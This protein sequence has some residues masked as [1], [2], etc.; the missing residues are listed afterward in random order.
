MRDPFKHVIQSYKHM[1]RAEADSD[2]ALAWQC[3]CE[4]VTY[5]LDNNADNTPSIG[6]RVLWR[7]LKKI[8]SG[9]GAVQQIEGGNHKHLVF[10]GIARSSAHRVEYTETETRIRPGWYIA[11]E[12]LPGHLQGKVS[13]TSFMLKALPIAVQCFV[14][15]KQRANR[16]LHIVHLAEATALRAFIAEKNIDVLYDYAPYHIDS[17]WLYL[18]NRDLLTSYIKIPSPGPL[19][20]HNAITL[21]DTLIVSS[22]YHEEE[23]QTLPNIRF[24][25]KVKWVVEQAHGYLGRYLSGNLA[26]PQPYTLGFYS[27]ASWLRKAQGHR[28]DGLNIDA[29]E[30]ELLSFLKSFLKHHPNYRLTIFMHPREK[31]ESVIDNARKYYTERL[32]SPNISFAHPSTKTSQSFEQV[33]IALAAFSTIVYERLFCGYKTLIGN[34]NI[35]NFPLKGSVLNNICFSDAAQMTT[36]IE[37]SAQQ[38]E[39]AFFQSNQLE[40]YHYKAYPTLQHKLTH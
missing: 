22:G 21:C 40:N 30:E 7:T 12:D 39:E 9:A 15:P 32:D 28:S 35:P 31:R 33:D 26:T 6:F 14:S 25:K 29:A 13:A 23:L 11:K 2:D 4:N 18:L 5:R 10:D 16:A 38:P 19:R 27:H 37:R 20:T 17:N 24:N 8:R 1:P 36:L 34:M 3:M